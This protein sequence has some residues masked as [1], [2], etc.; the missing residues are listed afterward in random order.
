MDF[1]IDILT[2]IWA[3]G[4]VLAV[5]PR[6]LYPY[7]TTKELAA[8]A[9]AWLIVGLCLAA[10]RP[11]T[12]APAVLV[13]ASGLTAW[14]LVAALKADRPDIA[15]AMAGR[16]SLGLWAGLLAGGGPCVLPAL[17]IA[18]LIDASYCFGRIKFN[19]RFF[20]EQADQSNTNGLQGNANFFGLTHLMLFFVAV[21]LGGWWLIAATVEL[22]AVVR[23]RCRSAMLGLFAGIF[24]A[25]TAGAMPLMGG[26]AVV[27]AAALG[28]GWSWRRT[29]AKSAYLR[30]GLWDAIWPA[31]RKHL[32][33]G[34]GHNN[35]KL[36]MPHLIRAAR[37]KG[38]LFPADWNCRRAHNDWIQAVADAGLPGAIGWL[39]LIVMAVAN[40]P[41]SGL[42]AGLIAFAVA[43]LAMHPLYVVPA[44]VAVV[45]M[46]GALFSG[47]A[48]V[49]LANAPELGL[50]WAVAG[51]LVVQPA[52]RLWLFRRGL[53]TAVDN[54][55][56]GLGR[57]MQIDPKDTMGNLML[58]HAALQHGRIWEANIFA[59]RA[60]AHYNGESMM[61]DV[62][63][64]DAAVLAMSGATQMA[65]RLM[66]EAAGYEGVDLEAQKPV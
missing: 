14:W 24:W 47:A 32:V 51:W 53:Q 49:P 5:W 33:F 6:T 8:V 31:L 44:Q 45:V 23:S 15:L 2:A 16:L 63:K 59:N 20:G 18:G 50:A 13:L 1:V 25:G 64:T 36:S 19:W 58:A 34:L 61:H 42:A 29:G 10:N 4:A 40:A 65:G 52:G 48:P 27:V 21:H 11:L 22:A 41:A 7:E 28:F 3:A 39:A 66:A 26:L 60:R 35:L 17:V 57:A 55:F 37:A 38:T 12:V 43:G 62:L 46:L 9:G 54:G 56:A 30:L